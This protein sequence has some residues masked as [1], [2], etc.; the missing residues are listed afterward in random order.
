MSLFLKGNVTI[1]PRPHTVGGLISWGRAVNRALIELRDRKVVGVVAKRHS[2]SIK[3]PLFITLVTHS[4]DPLEYEV[5]A[6][7]GHV[8]TRHNAGS[9]TGEPIEITALPT[10]DA[11]LAVI[12]DD[13]LWVKLTIDVDGKCTAA[14][15]ESGN[16]FPEDEPPE[17]VGGDDQSGT[18][19]QR[20]IRIA[21][22][23]ADP[24]STA[25][26][27]QLISDQ[28]HTGHIDHFQPTLSENTTTSPSAGE[29]RVMKEWNSSAGSFDFRFLKAE[30]GVEITEE[31]DRIVIRASVSHP[32]KATQNGSAFIAIAPGELLAA[33]FTSG[34]GFPFFWENLSYDGGSIEVTAATGYILIS[35]VKSELDAG[36]TNAGDSGILATPSSFIVEF[37]PT[38]A[39]VT[40]D[41]GF[42]IC[43]VALADG[44]ATVTK[45]ILTYN[46]SPS[47]TFISPAP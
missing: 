43:E 6:Q 46:P 21:E 35:I 23:I 36:S 9:E 47:I 26:T 19:G 31:A 27:P 7:F 22:I 37:Q 38:M 33:T 25:T 42:P 18:A 41:M 5:F 34:G 2:R 10:P 28:L 16:T 44:V 12:E 13:K 29:A 40:G 32:W 30:D 3:P 1:P 45:Q 11:P 17:L 24:G 4:T 14:D 39:E 20:Y 8:V 15:F